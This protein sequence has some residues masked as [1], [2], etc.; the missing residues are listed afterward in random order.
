MCECWTDQ[1]TYAQYYASGVDSMF[2]FTF[3]DKS[4][5][6]ANVV[7]GKA[8]AASYA[9][10]LEAEQA[11]YA[12]YNPDYINAP[13]YTNHDMG[14]ST[15]YYAGEN[16]AAQ[17][18]LGN[19]LNLLSSGSTFLYYGEELGMKG[20][21][22]DENKRAPMYW[23]KDDKAEGM[24][25]G[26]A[27]MEDFQ[28]K[29]DSLEE[30]Q[31]DPDSIYNYVKQVIRIRNQNPAIARG[32]TTYLEQYSG[33]QCFALTRS[34]EDSTLLLLGNTSAEPA[35]VDLSGLTVGNTAAEDLVL[36]GEL[37]TG[38]EIAEREGTAVTLPAYSVLILGEK[39][40][41]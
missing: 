23:S 37:Y 26:P 9:K 5:I 33:E 31:E 32:T 39:E 29:F 40:E 16:S 4:G 22:K 3:A 11:M 18:K 1:N 10:N 41:L 15:G 12:Q 7:N 21:G 34:Y 14:R 6:I 25:K 20:S 27:D 36:L 13:F 38:E 35:S 2:D 19:A 24:C 30:Q 8:S 28:M 17:T